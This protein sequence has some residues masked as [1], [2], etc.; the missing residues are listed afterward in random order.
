MQIRDLAASYFSFTADVTRLR[1]VLSSLPKETVRIIG[2]VASGGPAGAKG[3][4]A[5][6]LE[7]EKR[8]ALVCAV[9]G[10]VVVEQVFQH[11]F[12]AGTEEQVREMGEIQFTD[13]HEDGMYIQVRGRGCLVY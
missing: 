9:V 10:N 3:W 5:L 7:A 12:F 6:F 13:R 1:S 2:C 8:E 4:E 11:L